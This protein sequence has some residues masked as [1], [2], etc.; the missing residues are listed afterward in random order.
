MSVFKYVVFIL[1][2]AKNPKD[3]KPSLSVFAL[4]R[5]ANSPTLQSK[6]GS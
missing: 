4:K 2:V 3:K 6:K 1:N 5:K